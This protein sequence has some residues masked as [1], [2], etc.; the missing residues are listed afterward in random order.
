MAVETSANVLALPAAVDQAI[1]FL[2]QASTADVATVEHRTKRTAAVAAS[3]AFGV[4]LSAEAAEAP[5]RFSPPS[6][7]RRV[8]KLRDDQ[9][10]APIAALGEVTARAVEELHEL[11]AASRGLEEERA[12][13]RLASLEVG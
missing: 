7:E 13:H 4:K 3:A 10:P 1:R 6:P 12:A 5:R 8:K 11:R 9:L 2:G